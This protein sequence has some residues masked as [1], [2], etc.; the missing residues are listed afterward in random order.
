MG[1]GRKGFNSPHMLFRDDSL[2]EYGGIC[3]SIEG[4]YFRMSTAQLGRVA[5][6]GGMVD[7][8]RLLRNNCQLFP[9]TPLVFF[10]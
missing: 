9:Q 2:W 8:Q 7:M 1:F 3:H 10:P 6:K 5:T 4:G